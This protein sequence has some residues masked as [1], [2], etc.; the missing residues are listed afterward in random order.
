[1]ASAKPFATAPALAR[2]GYSPL[3]LHPKSQRAFLPQWP[4]Y[5][6]EPLSGED[7]E[8]FTR[9]AVPFNIGLA[10]GYRGLV[11]IDRDTDDADVIAA[12]RPVFR[13]IY[14][15]GGVPGAK[16]GTKG[17]TA[18]FRWQPDAPWRNRSIVSADGVVLIELSGAG[19][20]ATLPPSIHPKSLRPYTW[21][22]RRTLLDT[23]VDELPTLT[24]ADVA[25]IEV[26]LAPF[27]PPPPPRPI[28]AR[29]PVA[30]TD[31]ND[32]ERERHQRY[33]LTIIEREAAALAAMPAETGRN[34]KAFKLACRTGR[35]LHH[36]ILPAERIVAPIME[37]CTANGLVKDIGR[38]GVLAT[39]NSG[40][41]RAAN[42]TLTDLRSTAGRG[43]A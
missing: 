22:T 7:I 21:R 28:A 24:A 25:A 3:P 16:F 30:A 1:M 5:A 12:L 36:G 34:A 6:D 35:F 38:A 32:R 8:R 2:N 4:Q 29:P 33:A 19:R 31:L 10:L 17:L 18:F 11:A 27:A 9:S 40:L 43:A 39:I 13:C 15:R 14:G 41:R 42:D 26:A 20:C 37:A 23:R